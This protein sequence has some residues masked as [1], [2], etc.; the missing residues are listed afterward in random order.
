MQ[1]LV[2]C[3]LTSRLPSHTSTFEASSCK[4]STARSLAVSILAPSASGRAEDAVSRK[5]TPGSL[6]SMSKKMPRPIAQLMLLRKTP[7]CQAT[8]S[9][10]PQASSMSSRSPLS[11]STSLL[12][13]FRGVTLF[14]TGNAFRQQ[15]LGS[16]GWPSSDTRA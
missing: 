8:E 13:F 7:G 15:K 16:T 14:T 10:I 3:V 1:D 2:S 5:V 6:I 9:L 11:V 4:I 12:A